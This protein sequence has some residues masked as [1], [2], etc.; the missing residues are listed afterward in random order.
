MSELDRDVAARLRRAAHYADRVSGYALRSQPELVSAYHDDADALR[1]MAAVWPP[2]GKVT[3]Q[4]REAAARIVSFLVMVEGSAVL[5][6]EPLDDDAVMLSFMGNGASDV[7]LV[8]DFRALRDA[9]IT[10]VEAD[11]MLVRE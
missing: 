1:A 5:D 11:D 7:L 8:S 3:E 10:D 6:G 9:L 2:E 4:L